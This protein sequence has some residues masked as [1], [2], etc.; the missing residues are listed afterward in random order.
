M[1]IR[2]SAGSLSVCAPLAVAFATSSCGSQPWNFGAGPSPTGRVVVGE[3][4]VSLM[5]QLPKSFIFDP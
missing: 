5:N 4:Q 3:A 2:L 1:I